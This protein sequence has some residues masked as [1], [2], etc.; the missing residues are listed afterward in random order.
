MGRLTSPALVIGLALAAGCGGTAWSSRPASPPP[1]PASASRTW[2]SYRHSSGLTLEH[3]GTWKVESSQ[4][5]PLFVFIDSG[6]DDAGFRRNV[7]VLSQTLPAGFT[8]DD[9][10]SLSV[11]QM[12]KLGAAVDQSR[13]VTFA[14]VPGHEMTWHLIKA[15]KTLRFLEVWALRAQTAFLVTYTADSEGFDAPLGDVRRLFA[16]IR[17]P[18]SA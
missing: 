3:P 18:P 8:S 16:S 11:S 4:L 17:L 10:L 12:T 13:D 6:P 2:V 14:G 1:A 9:Y 7:N 15:G 5:G